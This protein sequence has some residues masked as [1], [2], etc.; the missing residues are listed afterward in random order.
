MNLEELETKKR[1]IETKIFSI[2]DPNNTSELSELLYEYYNV[3]TDIIHVK[4]LTERQIKISNIN[5]RLKK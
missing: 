2:T 4:L 1:F 5:K 3:R